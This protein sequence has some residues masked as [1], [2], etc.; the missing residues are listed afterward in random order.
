VVNNLGSICEAVC[1]S[2]N[3]VVGL[4]ICGY[5]S[6]PPPQ[7]L[8][9][10]VPL[11]TPAP[12]PGLPPPPPRALS[13]SNPD[14]T[15]ATQSSNDGEHGPGHVTGND[16]AEKSCCREQEPRRTLQPASDS[17][18]Q[19]KPYD[20]PTRAHDPRCHPKTPDAPLTPLDP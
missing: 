15:N 9:A 4:W 8:N 7:Q 16:G 10:A 13:R 2:S 1:P 19:G 20:P 12:P 6:F 18:H 3:L 5:Y 11:H 17:R 14:S